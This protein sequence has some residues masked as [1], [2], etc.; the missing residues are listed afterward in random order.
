MKVTGRPVLVWRLVRP[1]GNQRR[2]GSG[3]QRNPHLLA[4]QDERR[5]G[6]GGRPHSCHVRAHAGF[7]EGAAPIF[8]FLAEGTRKACF[9]APSPIEKA[10]AAQA[11]VHRHH[12]PQMRVRPLEPSQ[13]SLRPM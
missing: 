13:A 8:A 1:D 7:G 4:V 10:H 3:G 2:V 11:D 5:I 9:A 12:Y 6:G